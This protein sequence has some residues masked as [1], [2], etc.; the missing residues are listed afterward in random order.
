MAR[1]E[2][3]AHSKFNFPRIPAKIRIFIER[4]PPGALSNKP[5]NLYWFTLIYTA[6]CKDAPA[7]SMW[8]EQVFMHKCINTV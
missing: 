5:K 2:L 7:Q 4:E 6:R 1:Y 8:F 3:S